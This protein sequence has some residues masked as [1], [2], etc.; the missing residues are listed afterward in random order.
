M[1]KY[2]QLF[3]ISWQNGFVYRTSVLLWRLRNFLATYMALTIWSLLLSQGNSIAGYTQESAVTYIFVIS[4]LQSVVLSTS[5]HSMSE[6]IYSGGLSIILIRPMSVFAYFAIQEVTDKLKNFLFLLIETAALWYVFNPVLQLPDSATL[7]LFVAWT[8]GAVYLNGII[9]TLL[10]CIGFWS[11][12][13]WAPRFLFFIMLEFTAGKLFPLD[14]LP[15]FLQ[16][17]LFW[18]PLPY[19]SF[20]QTQ[21]FLGKLT[22]SVLVQHSMVFAL[23]LVIGTLAIQQVWNRGMRQYVAAGQ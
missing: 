6:F 12:E 15:E 11:P 8:L 20:I 19:L 16:K 22:G 17:I 14:I 13:T 5:L 23:W 2:V 4:L 10:G 1:L 18:T 9:L 7:L 3:S 21:L